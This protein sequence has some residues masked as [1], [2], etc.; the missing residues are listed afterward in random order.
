MTF[1][2]SMPRAETPVVTRIGQIP[3]RKAR[4]GDC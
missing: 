3:V 4:L 2:I 1:L